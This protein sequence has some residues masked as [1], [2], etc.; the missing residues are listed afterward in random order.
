M[1]REEIGFFVKDQRVIKGLTQQ[2]LADKAGC[3]RQAVL[4]VENNLRNFGIDTLLL[5]LNALE[6][7]LPSTINKKIFN[8]SQIKSIK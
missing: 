8:F 4:E 5:L 2:Q 6:T 3:R 1:T 7:N